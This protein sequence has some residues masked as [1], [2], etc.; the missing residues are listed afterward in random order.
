MINN[1]NGTV[2]IEFI[3][4]Q[5][6][7]GQGTGNGVCSKVF[8]AHEP[9]LNRDIVI[10]EILREN[11]NHNYYQ[12]A[13]FL[14]ESKHPNVVEIHYAGSSGI[15]PNGE[16]YIYLAMPFYKN[17]SI[18]ERINS[19]LTMT[20]IIHYSIGF[21]EGLACVH[22]KSLLHLDI[23]LDNILISNSNDAL[24]SD[25]G[26]VTRFNPNRAL[27]LHNRRLCELIASP[28]VIKN[29]KAAIPTDIYQ[30]GIVMYLLAQ[31][32]GMNAFEHLELNDEEFRNLILKGQLFPPIYPEHISLDF[33]KIVNKCLHIDPNKRFSSVRG[34]INDLAK[35][36]PSKSLLWNYE[37]SGNGDKKW[38]RTIDNITEICKLSSNGEVEIFSINKK[39]AKNIYEDKS[40]NKSKLLD[41]LKK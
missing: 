9:N 37:L 19:P 40:S 21:L 5:Q 10:K 30:A 22:A 17:N 15:L 2:L 4:K 23:K 14:N 35:I 31:K 36:K 3:K 11:L 26:L 33:Q 25:F 41:Y 38:I 29:A 28:E 27:D 18:K 16:E 1:N 6:I 7:G 13:I 39:G 24:L 12:E 8:L 34:I 32:I 20:D